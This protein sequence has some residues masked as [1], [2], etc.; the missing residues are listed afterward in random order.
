MTFSRSVT[1]AALAASAL[2]LTQPAG[3]QQSLE[4]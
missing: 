1:I 3:A 2:L 4:Q